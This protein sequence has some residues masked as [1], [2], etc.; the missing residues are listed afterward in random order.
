MLDHV[1]TIESGSLVLDDVSRT[2]DVHNGDRL[3]LQG[4]D[5]W[6]TE[7]S[8]ENGTLEL[9][10]KGTVKEIRAGPRGSEKDL[11]PSLLEYVFSNQPVAL[12]FGSVV[13]LWGLL[14]GVVSHLR[15]V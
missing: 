3:I 11:S 10:F 13:F 1:S 15:R 2:V 8:I 5:G 14:N 9:F 12:F 4:V 7:F 6:I